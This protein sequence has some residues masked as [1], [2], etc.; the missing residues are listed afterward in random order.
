[1]V[2]LNHVLILASLQLEN[3]YQAGLI[4]NR[5]HFRIQQFVSL[6]N[7]TSVAHFQHLH[8]SAVAAEVS[9]NV[10][11][12]ISSVLFTLNPISNSVLFV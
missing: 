4:N 8:A 1:M 2:G 10:P 3:I 11:T 6:K 5:R 7:K 12:L 9:R